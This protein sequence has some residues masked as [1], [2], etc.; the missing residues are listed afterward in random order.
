MADDAKS[1]DTGPQRLLYAQAMEHPKTSGNLTDACY[2]YLQDH[3]GVVY[4]GAGS[5]GARSGTPSERQR[6]SCRAA[7]RV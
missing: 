7:C 4:F 3:P 5:P 2:K 6:L 1:I